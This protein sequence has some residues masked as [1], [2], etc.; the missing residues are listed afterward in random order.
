MKLFLVGFCT[1]IL[2]PQ[3]NYWFASHDLRILR[4]HQ[5]D[6]R[7]IDLWSLR[8]AACLLAGLPYG[9][10]L[11]DPS[12]AMR[13]DPGLFSRQGGLVMAGADPG[14]MDTVTDSH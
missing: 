7:L 11:R 10:R 5:H 12:I 3:S 2:S 13:V 1:D 14:I 6:W 9:C 8:R 4:I